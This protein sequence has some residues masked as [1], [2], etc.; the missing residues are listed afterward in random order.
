MD[1][2]YSHGFYNNASDFQPTDSQYAYETTGNDVHKAF[3]N[4]VNRFNRIGT[5]NATVRV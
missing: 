3:F 4:R 1:E 2:G 5:E